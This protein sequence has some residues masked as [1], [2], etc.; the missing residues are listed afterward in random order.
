MQGDLFAGHPFFASFPALSRS[1]RPPL[2][3]G[4]L[5][6]SGS[7]R[8]TVPTVRSSPCRTSDILLLPAA[9][10]FNHASDLNFRTIRARLQRLEELEKLWE[11][12]QI[13]TYS[14]K[15]KSTLDRERTKINSGNVANRE[16]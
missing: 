13:D 6:P 4:P 2:P 3:F 9:L 7:K 12:G 10:S 5:Q 15:M 8:S 11:T 1:R 14:K 16:R